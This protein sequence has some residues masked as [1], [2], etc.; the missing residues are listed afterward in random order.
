MRDPIAPIVVAGNIK[1][2]SPNG[3]QEIGWGLTDLDKEL[4]RRILKKYG[5]GHR[6]VIFLELKLPEF[7]EP[8]NNA[9]RRTNERTASRANQ[10]F[11]AEMQVLWFLEQILEEKGIM[12]VS[13]PCC[14]CCANVLLSSAYHLV[15]EFWAGI[16]MNNIGGEFD[17]ELGRIGGK[18]TFGHWRQNENSWSHPGRN[19]SFMSRLGGTR[20]VVHVLKERIKR[21]IALNRRLAIWERFL[22]RKW[23]L[24]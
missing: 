15:A 1:R 16:D 13:K 24:L 14:T 2:Y 12:G 23:N 19:I 20:D 4:T 18:Y 11:H 7:E 21:K 8:R 5:L 10:Q 3:K 22:A 17:V 6:R 9:E